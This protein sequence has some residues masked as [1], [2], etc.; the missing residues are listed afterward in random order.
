MAV[1]VAAAY[2][3]ASQ[4]KHRRSVGFWLFLAGNAL[5]IA[6]AWYANAT[7]LIV[8]QVALAAM[9]VRGAWKN[10]PQDA[11]LPPARSDGGP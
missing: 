1:T 10:E 2:L 5:W 9:N 4:S 11:P 7:A 8:L 6:W 3:V